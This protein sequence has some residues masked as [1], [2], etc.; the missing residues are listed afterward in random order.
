MHPNKKDFTAG[1][2]KE[3]IHLHMSSIL[4]CKDDVP[5]PILTR[6]YR[7]DLSAPAMEARV[8]HIATPHQG[9]D[10]KDHSCAQGWCQHRPMI[11]LEE[12]LSPIE[13]RDSCLG[14]G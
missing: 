5:A 10:C 12:Y 4:A 8:Q 11:V 13:S 6:P 7:H 2:G 3:R 1:A 14:L 9:K